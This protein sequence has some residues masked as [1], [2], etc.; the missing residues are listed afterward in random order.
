MVLKKFICEDCY[1]LQCT[2]CFVFSTKMASTTENFP[3][4]IKFFKTMW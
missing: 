1:K 2:F 4:L 3:K